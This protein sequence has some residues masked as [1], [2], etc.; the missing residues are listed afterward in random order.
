MQTQKVH[1]K[2]SPLRDSGT[3]WIVRTVYQQQKSSCMRCA[4]CHER[5]YKM[6]AFFPS[7]RHFV[8]INRIG[9]RDISVVRCRA[10][11]VTVLVVSIMQSIPF[12]LSSATVLRTVVSF[13]PDVGIKKQD[14]N[15]L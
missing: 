8:G 2:W 9:R 1:R 11:T 14:R 4:V 7:V 3:T 10:T 13:H 15:V 12:Q 6:F 5:N